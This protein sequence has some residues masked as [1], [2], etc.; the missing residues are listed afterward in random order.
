[1]KLH[2]II[3]TPQGAQQLRAMR[4]SQLG[5]ELIPFR[6]P[7]CRRLEE[8]RKTQDALE[9]KQADLRRQPISDF[10]ELKVE[11]PRSTKISALKV[12]GFNTA[13]PNAERFIQEVS[14]A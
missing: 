2:H 8:L 6:N 5:R 4:I 12:L 11:L 1:M 9:Q 10:I 3:L 7:L 14:V 13:R